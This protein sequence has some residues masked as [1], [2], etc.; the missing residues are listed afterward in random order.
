MVIMPTLLTA[1]ERAGLIHHL[2][3]RNGISFSFKNEQVKRC[4][5]VAGQILEIRIAARMRALTEKDGAPLYHD[6]RVGVSI[7]WDAEAEEKNER[8]RTVN[9]IDVLAMKGT[10]PIF[11]SCKNGEFDADELYKLSTVAYRFGGSYAK[12][13]LVVSDIDRMGTRGEYLL[14]RAADMGIR[15]LDNVSELDNT[16]LDR[17][18]RSLWLN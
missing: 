14:A 1:L 4:L 5:T 15:V 8:V 3:M 2:S 13:V 16:E 11:I 18:L 6:C 10:I 7:N 17:L 12:R 9:E